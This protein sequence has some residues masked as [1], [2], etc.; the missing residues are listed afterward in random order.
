MGDHAREAMLIALAKQGRLDAFDELVRRHYGAVYRIALRITRNPA[1]AEDAT[2]EAFERSWKAIESFRGGC[3][4]LTW[5]YRIVTNICRTTQRRRGRIVPLDYIGEAP[6]SP[7]RRPD[8]QAE[9][10]ACRAA[11]TKAIMDLTPE[12]R[13]PLVLR[14]FADCSYDQI[15]A[16]LGVTAQA[17][18]G[19]L[20]RARLELS[21][22]MQS[23]Q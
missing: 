8:R 20:H 2:Q 22:A 13:A 11:L 17:V 21:E 23:W 1:D 10:T 18:R 19:R 4:F 9:E 7:D 12:Q 16:R 3:S 15:A 14:E 6:D 5:M